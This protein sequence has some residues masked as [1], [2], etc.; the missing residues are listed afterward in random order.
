[1]KCPKCKKAG[2]YIRFK[3]KEVVC[4]HCGNIQKQNGGKK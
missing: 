1:M 4:R 3:T 2:A